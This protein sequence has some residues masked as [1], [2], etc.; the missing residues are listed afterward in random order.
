MSLYSFVDK[1]QYEVKQ[2][3]PTYSGLELLALEALL[4]KV[5]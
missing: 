4:R 1:E 2:E 3:K 5:E